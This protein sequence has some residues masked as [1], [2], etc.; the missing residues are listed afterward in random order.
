[1][2]VVLD[3]NVLVSA[4]LTPG[5]SAHQVIQLVLRGDLQ[6]C[7]DSRIVAEYRE[8]LVR[9]K[10]GFS[11]ALVE[12]FL[13]ALLEEAQEILP[14]PL[15]GRFPDEADRAFLE[16]AVSG[17]AEGVVTGNARHFHAAEGWGIPVKSP[18]EFLAWWAQR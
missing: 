9:S 18:G 16:V 11:P 7:V 6:L 3:T 1:M 14:E 13:E 10:F 8:I 2:R 4:I 12:E 17:G 5:G 15:P